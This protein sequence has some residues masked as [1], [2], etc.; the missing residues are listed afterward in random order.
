MASFPANQ[1]CAVLPD[2]LTNLTSSPTLISTVGGL[3]SSLVTV[4]SPPAHT[5]PVVGIAA[6]PIAPASIVIP[7]LMGSMTCVRSRLGLGRRIH[8]LLRL[9]HV[10]LPA[11]AISRAR[12]RARGV[13]DTSAGIQALVPPRDDTLATLEPLRDLDALG[14][15][16]ARHH[17]AWL[18]APVLRHP[19]TRLATHPRHRGGRYGHRGGPL[20]GHEL[21]HHVLTGHEPAGGV[22]HERLDDR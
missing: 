8:W 2:A 18:R 3:F 12:S 4:T 16:Q 13:P 21:H 10:R 17:R 9:R 7:V 22:V 1:T 6:R 11:P 5:S 19:H 14:V 20:A 15:L